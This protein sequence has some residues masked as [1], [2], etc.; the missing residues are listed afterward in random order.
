MPEGPEIRRSA[1][2]LHRVLCGHAPHALRFA[3]PQLKKYARQLTGQVIDTVE[4]RGKAMLIHFANGMSIYSHNQLYGEWM[5]FPGK[6]P[7]THLQERLLIATPAGTA[8]LYSASEIAVLPTAA[9][10]QHSYIAKLGVDLL[11]A[12]TTAADVLRQ[13]NDP[14]FARRGLAG[15]LLDQGFL[16]GLGNY[17]RSEIL[18]VCR[19]HP[20]LRPAD[21]T[22]QQRRLLARQASLITRRS[23][24]TAGITNNLVLA[25]RLKAQGASF[26]AFRHAVFERAGLPCYACGNNIVRI[27]RGRALFMCPHCQAQPAG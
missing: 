7:V 19:L 1:D 20:D 11:G 24:R 26:G 10:S 4:P 22:P 21:L 3:F 5:V 23:Y 12:A 13:V 17:L 2:Q 16:A 15:L 25:R 18:F 6:P 9:L 14:R 8:V 27:E